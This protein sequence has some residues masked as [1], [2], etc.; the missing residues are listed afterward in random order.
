MRRKIALVILAS[1]VV[2]LITVLTYNNTTHSRTERL[3]SRTI[4]LQA[5]S[6]QSV[7]G[8]LFA[9]GNLATV[10]VHALSPV[11]IGFI[12]ESFLA[13]SGV[14]IAL[15]GAPCRQDEVLDGTL[16]CPLPRD[17]QLW[18][19]VIADDRTA[20][21]AAGSGLAAVLGIRR[22]AEQY[23]IRNDVTVRMEAVVCT[24]NCPDLQ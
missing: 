2:V 20:L 24:D 3:P 16:T 13:G 15:Q 12:P 4:A 9:G 11:T 18:A 17:P 19:L 10:H 7:T 8:R 6:A 1:A 14:R 22:P 5:G 23:L 21:G